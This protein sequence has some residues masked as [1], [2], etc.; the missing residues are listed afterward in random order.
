MGEHCF[1]R[2]NSNPPVCGVH[3]A[4]L[5]QTHTSDPNPRASFFVCPASG[6]TI[7]ELAALSPNLSTLPEL[8]RLQNAQLERLRQ[9]EHEKSVADPHDKPGIQ[10]Y[11]DD[12]TRDIQVL[13]LEIQNRKLHG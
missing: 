7:E 4:P 3:N 9:L 6:S 2:K 12:V 8:H 5:Q 11:I 10:R 13:D 1:R